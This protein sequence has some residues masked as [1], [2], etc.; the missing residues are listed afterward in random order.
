MITLITM[1]F[2]LAAKPDHAVCWSIV[3]YL[4]PIPGSKNQN[5]NNL[6]L[7]LEC[8]FETC[9]TFRSLGQVTDYA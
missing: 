2:L 7:T 5:D 1:L 9:A 4:L 8:S 3:H 6:K